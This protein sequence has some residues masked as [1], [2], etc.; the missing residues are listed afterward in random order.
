MGVERLD[1]ASLENWPWEA[2]CK[3]RGPVDAPKFRDYIFALLFLKELSDVFDEEVTRLAQ[4]FGGVNTSLE[5]GRGSRPAWATFSSVLSSPGNPVAGDLPEDHRFQ[6]VPR[7]CSANC[8]AG[9]PEAAGRRRGSGLQRHCGRAAHNRRPTAGRADAGA[10]QKPL[11]AG[12]CG[13]ERPGSSPQVH[14]A[15][16]RRG[17]GAK[18]RPVLYSARRTRLMA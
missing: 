14:P 3:I 5:A 1:L 6:A 9:K 16:V 13:A 8:S 2:A 4:E 15:V 11:G 10:E 17:A 18:R 7:R 12:G